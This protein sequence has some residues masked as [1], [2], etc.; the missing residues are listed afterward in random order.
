MNTSQTA[1]KK[2]QDSGKGGTQRAL[3][4]A[5][6]IKQNEF[7]GVTRMELARDTGL[8]INA[9]C[10]RVKEL[11]DAELIHVGTN[12]GACSVTKNKVELLWCVNG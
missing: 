5:Q 4:L 8:G 6:V 2:L 9:I 1:Y 12:T 7:L 3:V 10:G 11:I